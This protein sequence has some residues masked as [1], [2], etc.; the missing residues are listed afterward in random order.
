MISTSGS[1]K[2]KPK[3]STIRT[4]KSRILST[5]RKFAAVSGVMLSSTFML[6]GMT[7]KAR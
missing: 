5:S 3:I 6:T 2:E 4:A 1:S 7:T